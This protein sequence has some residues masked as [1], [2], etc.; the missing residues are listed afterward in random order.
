MDLPVAA[1][2]DEHGG[3]ALQRQPRVL[4]RGGDA[5]GLAQIPGQ[6][7]RQDEVVDQR[8]EPP[9]D[10]EVGGEGEREDHRVRGDVAARVVAD[11]QHRPLGRDPLQPAH[12][13]AEVEGGEHPEP[14]QLLA[15]VVGVALVQVRH[16][17]AVGDR[18]LDLLA[19]GELADAVHYL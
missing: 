13:G 14:R 2:V 7:Q 6:R 19:G 18:L 4:G 17:D 9:L 5:A 10:A 3:A 11:Q 15:Q 12:V 16:G 1:R 8:V